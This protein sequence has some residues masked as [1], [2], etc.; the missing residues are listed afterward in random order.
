MEV[1]KQ[2]T[3]YGL[4]MPQGMRGQVKAMAAVNGRSMNSEIIYHLKKALAEAEGLEDE[5][6]TV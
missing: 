2:D 4:R 6:T 1:R 5:D 3:P